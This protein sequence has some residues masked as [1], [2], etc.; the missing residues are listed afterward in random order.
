MR[1]QSK[2]PINKV[3]KQVERDVEYDVLVVTVNPEDIKV[4]NNVAYAHV[5]ART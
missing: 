1:M 5:T 3:R 4:C 2:L